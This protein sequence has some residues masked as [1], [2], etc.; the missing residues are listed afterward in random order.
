MLKQDVVRVVGLMSGTSLDGI[1][2]AEIV[3]DG[4]RVLEFGPVAYR[5]YTDAER[6]LLKGAM[7]RWQDD[8]VAEVATMVE[9]LHAEVAAEF[10][11][12]DL[13]GF[14]GQTLA[15]DPG[16]RGTHQAGDGAELARAL[17]KPVVWDFRSADVMMGGQ[18]APLAPFYHFALAQHLARHLGADAPLAMLNLGGV[19]NLT[20]IDPAASAPEMDGAL[21]AFDTGPANAPINDLVSTRTGAAF[22]A[23]GAL[24]A[25]GTVDQDMV[26]R[27][28]HH[29]YFYKVPPKSLDRDAFADLLTDV[30]DLTLQDACAT[31]TAAAAT[32]ISQAVTFCPTPPSHILV[33]GGGRLN[34]T[35]MSMI[36]QQVPM[37]VSAI[38]DVGFDG[39]QLEAQ[40]FAYLA[41]RVLKGLPTSAPGTTGVAAAIGGGTVSGPAS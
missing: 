5:P 21:L 6:A 14:H 39:D 10:A 8:D 35:M 9:D 15:H 19:G 34:P 2:A 11:D 25:S 37:T 24:A 41:A 23:Q 7:G 30:A 26:E 1:D 33:A 38:E 16:G 28:M 27:F 4:H 40:A 13:V 17:G 29:A 36:A 18:G 22:D 12:A 31:L 20:W 32:A 3:T